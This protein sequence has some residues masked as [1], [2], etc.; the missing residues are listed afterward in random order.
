MTK[1]KVKRNNNIECLRVFAMFLIVIHHSVVSGLGLNEHL[2][3]GIYCFNKINILLVFLNSFA[4]VSVNVFF[5]ISGYFTI[6][7]SMK[8][9]IKLYG[10]IAFYSI[11]IYLVFV[12]SGLEKLTIKNIVKY[13]IFAVNDY[14]FMIVYL[15][16]M[17]ISPYLNIV[18]KEISSDKI[19]YTSLIA[20]MFFIVCVYGFIFEKEVVGTNKGYSLINAIMLYL[21]GNFINEQKNSDK[22]GIIKGRGVYV[23]CALIN[24]CGIY[25]LIRQNHGIMAWKLF[26][27]N[28]PLIYIQAVALFIFFT[29]LKCDGIGKYISGLGKY[30]LGI[31]LIHSNPFVIPYRFKLLSDWVSELNLIGDVVKIILYCLILY[32]IC[33]FIEI[34]RV[35][36]I[37]GIKQIK[38]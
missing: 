6:K 9:F 32:I 12:I 2:N 29:N 8:K 4:I 1:I 5:L 37:K 35:L 30:T 25:L 11:I 31:Y 19:K 13:S 26:S 38:K 36:A 16:L 18:I 22:V 20:I 28:N 3:S 7:F 17:L 14:W 34:I 27:Y 15:L 21:T 24:F 23:I 10:E 33:N